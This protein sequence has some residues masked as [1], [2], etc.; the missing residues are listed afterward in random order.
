MSA[1]AILTRGFVCPPLVALQKQQAEKEGLVKPLSVKPIIQARAAA[2]ITAAKPQV[3][4]PLFPAP[5]KPKPQIK[6]IGGRVG[7]VKVSVGDSAPAPAPSSTSSTAAPS[8]PQV[9]AHTGP[10]RPKLQVKKEE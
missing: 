8:K 9:K 1:L 10:K 7:R 5:P 3:V 2:K 6:A 4:E